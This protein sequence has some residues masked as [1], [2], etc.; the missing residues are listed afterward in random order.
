[1]GIDPSRLPRH[2][3]IIMDGNGRWARQRGMDRIEGHRQGAEAARETVR[4]CREIGIQVLTLFAFSE[5]NW[6]RPELEVRA[7]WE[8]LV[9]YLESERS[10]MLK[11]GIRL[12]A[13]GDLGR[14]PREV[15]MGLRAL[16]EESAT[17]RDMT[18][19]LALS[20]GGREDLVTATRRIAQEV[21]AGRLDP[22]GIGA[23]VIERHL[24]TFGLG[25]LDLLI[26]TSGERR[27]SNFMLWPAA[28]AELHF[29]DALWPDFRRP[30]L[31][32]ALED[33]QARERRFGRTD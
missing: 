20:Y 8:L 19:C 4:A 15:V 17:Q 7:L 31:E 30:H 12:T 10:E 22:D 26:R 9:G 16:C 27:I 18:L 25:D 6:E 29:C 33:Y 23:D 14:L 3:G 5:Q 2:V 13:I 11:N 1:M 28:Y 24:Q 21:S 32:A